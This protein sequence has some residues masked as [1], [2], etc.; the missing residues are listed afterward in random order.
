M[1]WGFASETFP[2][3]KMYNASFKDRVYLDMIH[4]MQENF[5]LDPVTEQISTKKFDNHINR[6]LPDEHIVYF[7]GQDNLT[8]I[9]TSLKEYREINWTVQQIR[10]CIEGQPF[11]ILSK[12]FRDTKNDIY[13]ILSKLHESMMHN[14]VNSTIEYIPKALQKIEKF[15][16]IENVHT[17]DLYMF[18]CQDD[19]EAQVRYNMFCLQMGIEANPQLLENIRK[20]LMHNRTR[21]LGTISLPDAYSDTVESISNVL[22]NV[23]NVKMDTDLIDIGW[24]NNSQLALK[25]AFPDTEMDY[26]NCY[27]IADLIKE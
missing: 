13:D 9:A 24:N 7:N 23:Y 22:L 12:A 11:W 10:D 8:D 19:D 25:L 21:A 4:R 15:K 3:T 6:H 14:I 2:N 5:D 27:T 16:D 17:F 20:D 26:D 18:F 1:S